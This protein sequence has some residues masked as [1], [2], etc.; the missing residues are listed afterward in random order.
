MREITGP[1]AND[2]VKALPC[3]LSRRRTRAHR[4]PGSRRRPPAAPL[5]CLRGSRASAHHRVAARPG[6]LG[7]PNA[8]ERL[9]AHVSG[10]VFARAGPKPSLTGLERAAAERQQA[11]QGTAAPCTRFG[12][13]GAESVALPLSHR[14]PRTHP[15]TP[16][17]GPAPRRR[18]SG[19]SATAA[20]SSFNRTI[21][22]HSRP[23]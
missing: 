21:R 10:L 12:D 23:C 22:T 20:A 15:A 4:S 16:T 14:L 18:G 7:T 11:R 6:A 9:N 3:G 1:E 17:S 19:P 13:R 5:R 8:G 2:R